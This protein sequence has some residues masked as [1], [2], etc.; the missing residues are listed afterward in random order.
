MPVNSVFS[1]DDKHT[2][3]T[4]AVLI[5]QAKLYQPTLLDNTNSLMSC[6]ITNLNN[7]SLLL[8][9]A[10]IRCLRHTADNH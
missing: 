5:Q 6:Y 4:V 3:G 10:E 9:A 2:R 7:V 1:V 8:T